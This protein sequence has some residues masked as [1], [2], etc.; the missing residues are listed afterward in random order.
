MKQ[1]DLRSD[2]VTLPTAAI[3]VSYTHLAGAVVL[4]VVGFV[5]YRLAVKVVE[6]KE[7]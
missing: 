7:F 5:S 6:A 4:L 3:P 2:T 1:I